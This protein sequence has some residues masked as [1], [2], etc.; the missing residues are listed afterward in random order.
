MIKKSLILALLALVT[1]GI[2]YVVWDYLTVDL[3]LD[4]GGSWDKAKSRCIGVAT[5]D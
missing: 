1:L 3:C 2:G 4:R 5:T